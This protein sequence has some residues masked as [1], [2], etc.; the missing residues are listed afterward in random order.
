M[1]QEE[2]KLKSQYYSFIYQFV[3]CWYG[4]CNVLFNYSL[5]KL[6]LIGVNTLDIA[7]AKQKNSLFERYWPWTV[8][9]V[10]IGFAI[11]YLWFLGQADFVIDKDIV[12]YDQVKQG[13]F[14]VSVRGTGLLIPDN[15][16]WLSANV[17]ARVE[18]V[19]VKAGKLVK[20]GDLIVELSNPQLVQLLEETQWE[21]EA[22][23]A[24]SKAEKVQQKSALLMQKAMMLD[25]RLN[26]ESSKLKQEAHTELFHKSTGAVS[27]IDYEQTRLETIQLKQRWEIQQDVLTS[28]KENVQ[29]QDNARIAR[30]KKMKKTLE[31]AQQQVNS[32]MI[33]ASIDSVVQEVP[34]EPGQRIPMGANI[35]KLAQQNSLIAELQV[36]ELQIRD[37]VIGQSVTIDT[38]NNK[39]AGIVSRVDPAV[40]NGNVQVDVK[41]VGDLPKDAR[42]DLSVDGEI[43]ITELT[44]VL[45]VNRPIF[46]QSQSTS[47]IYKVSDDGNFAER[48][49]VK[50]GKGSINKIQIIEGLNVGDNIIIS[51]PSTWETYQKIRID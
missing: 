41:F 20:K 32:L 22:K 5:P 11:N 42:P 29:A 1:G 7:I 43:K 26:Y 2:K 6:Y 49:N 18:R 45:Y 28:M 31:R 16:Q 3:R 14:S 25:A 23:E 39:V 4:I 8:I 30:L 10:I 51:D 12:V 46:A 24:E 19:V 38:R 35:A 13:D 48:T 27:K 47:A 44:E 37:V 33:V 50:F 17:E 21:L 36:P 34:V 9:I 15:I 40:V